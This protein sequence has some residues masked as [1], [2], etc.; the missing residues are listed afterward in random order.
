MVEIVQKREGVV[1]PFY[2][3]LNHIP[4]P[5]RAPRA[6]RMVKEYASKHMKTEIDKVLLH[7]SVNEYIWN[8]GI[9]KPPRKIIVDMTKDDEDYVEVF[10]AGEQVVQPVI[11]APAELGEGLEEPIEPEEEEEEEEE[12]D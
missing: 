7:E 4:R 6:V 9:E 5:R 11:E 2:P 8:R 10:L 3:K 1:I 12:E